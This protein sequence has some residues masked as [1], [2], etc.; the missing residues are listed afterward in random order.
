MKSYVKA[1]AVMH[2]SSHTSIMKNIE[3][4][5]KQVEVERLFTGHSRGVEP[6]G[7]AIELYNRVKPLFD[8]LELA[9]KSFKDFNNN[10]EAVIRIII[11]SSFAATYLKTFFKQFNAKYPNVKI[12][13]YNRADSTNYD[14]YL[15]GKV[16]LVVDLEHALKHY[17]SH[18]IELVKCTHIF[19]ATKEFLA[20]N[21]L[22]KTITKANFSKYKVIAHR[23]NA[24]MFTQKSGFVLPIFL[25]TATLGPILPF[26]ET[27]T[28]V[29]LYPKQYLR[30]D[31][32]FIVL[33]SDISVPDTSISCGYNQKTISKAAKVFIDALLG[34]CALS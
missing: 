28:G 17:W 1:A 15:R 33:N 7:E 5:A 8:D 18:T 29:G 32:K 13:F 23:E 21:N 4:L 20:E 11:P 6:T 3:A 30:K 22:D 10:S 12:E 9:E 2:Y 34:F 31:H 27:G 19:I 25:E 26:V 16:D 14:R 24:R